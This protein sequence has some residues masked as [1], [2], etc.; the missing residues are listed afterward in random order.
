MGH[1]FRLALRAD[2]TEDAAE[3][4]AANGIRAWRFDDAM[5]STLELVVP[6]TVRPA[7]GRAARRRLETGMRDEGARSNSRIA[8]ITREEYLARESREE[9]VACAARHE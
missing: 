8:V 5:A 2:V 4:E 1:E 6:T 7:F 3:R 9:D